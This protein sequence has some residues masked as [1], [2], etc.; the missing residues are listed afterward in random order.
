[1]AHEGVRDLSWSYRIRMASTPKDLLPFYSIWN[2][3][4]VGVILPRR[5]SSA[6]STRVFSK[7]TD[8]V[9][10]VHRI[11]LTQALL[12]IGVAFECRLK[13]GL[14]AIKVRKTIGVQL[15]RVE[16]GRF[17]TPCCL[18]GYIFRNTTPPGRHRNQPEEV[19]AY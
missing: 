18:A 15:N 9:H 7:I 8:Y 13:E 14:R 12:I 2:I 17:L 3:Q 11:V 6:S 10:H 5:S 16:R 1:M 4:L 19:K